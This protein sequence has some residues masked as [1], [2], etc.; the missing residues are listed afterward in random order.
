[1]SSQPAVFERFFSPTPTTPGSPND[2]DGLT[3]RFTTTTRYRDTWAEPND[4]LARAR[5][6]ALPFLSADVNH[7]TEI[8]GPNDV[9]F[10]RFSAT[11]G[12]VIVAQLIAGQIDSVLGLYDAGGRLLAVDDDS[13]AGVLSRIVFT[14]PQDGHYAVAV[15]T[16]PDFQFDGGGTGGTGRYVLDV[17]EQPT[18]SATQ[19]L[20]SV[21]SGAPAT[22]SVQARFAAT[23][24]PGDRR[25]TDW[26]CLVPPL[27]AAWRPT[28]M[29][30]G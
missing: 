15:S 7:I 11:A 16:F 8:S 29:R 1:M 17:H 4:T 9:D 30:V 22:A 26:W 5:R 2:L 24:P 28:L 3:L 27:T 6:I 18:T 19:L 23:A 13:G 14:I 25:E 12:Q 21:E 10:F 20:Q